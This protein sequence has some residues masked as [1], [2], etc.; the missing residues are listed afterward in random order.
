MLAACG[1]AQVPSGWPGAAVQGDRL[2]TGT[3]DRDVRAINT[4]NGDIV[5]KFPLRGEPEKNRAI[6]GTPALVDDT[7]YFGGY[8]G[9][10][11][12]VGTDGREVWSIKVGNGHP[13]VGSPA[14]ADGKVLIG[15]TDHHLYAFEAATGKQIW[16]FETANMVW[17]SPTV[18]KGIVYFGSLDHK[19]Y[20]L[21]ISDGKKVWEFVA[22]GAVASKPLVAAG[23][24]YFGSFGSVF[25]AINATSGQRLWQFEG[26]KSWYWADPI[27]DDS[28]VYAPSLDGKLYALD[29]GTGQPRWELKTNGQIVSAPAMLGD[30]VLVGSMDGRVRIVRTVDGAEEYQCNIEAAVRA[31]LIE[32]NDRVYFSALDHTIRALSIKSNGNPDEEWVHRTDEDDPVETAGVSAC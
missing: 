27:K 32:A 22:N 15:S 21:K 11:Y 5:W 1:G 30:R 14:V 20:A 19:V 26:A 4:V 10:L 16:K 18:D 6:Y 2:Y 12:A 23:R 24:V 3:M 31:P 17:S 8:D 7:L 13:F 29:A 28:T 25:Y 9:L